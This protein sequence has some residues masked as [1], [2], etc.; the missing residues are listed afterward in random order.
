[1]LYPSP[2]TWVQIVFCI[3]SFS[4]ALYELQE[5]HRKHRALAKIR[6]R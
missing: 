3:V 1:M 6:R 5:L 2:D 4:W